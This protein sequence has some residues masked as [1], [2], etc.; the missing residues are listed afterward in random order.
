[1]SKSPNALHWHHPAFIRPWRN[2]YKTAVRSLSRQTQ[3]PSTWKW[4]LLR[5]RTA[6]RKEIRSSAWRACGPQRPVLHG[7]R[8]AIGA[9]RLRNGPRGYSV[10]LRECATSTLFRLT[11]SSQ[12]ILG[13]DWCF[14][15][16]DSRDKPT[17]RAKPVPFQ[18]R[19]ALRRQRPT[20]ARRRP[21]VLNCPTG[22]PLERCRHRLPEPHDSRQVLQ[23]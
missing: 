8:F 15:E 23:H 11:F 16:S 12:Q 20:T 22:F 6:R 10:P 17:R 1:L 7:C 21:N 14:V 3:R 4:S 9:W 13:N 2:G 5:W 19:P 18:L